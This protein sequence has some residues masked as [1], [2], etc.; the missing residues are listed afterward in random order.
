MPD[1]LNLSVLKDILLTI[2]ALYGA[3][4]STVN[5]RQAVRKEHR[6][7]AVK[8]STAMPAWGSKMGNCY[9]RIEATN[10]GHRPV[11]VSTLT[12]EL[13]SGKRI[14][15]IGDGFPGVSDTSLPASLSDGG[16]AH[17]LMAYKDI[18][19]ALL[20]SG[21]TGKTKITPICVD[22]L[23]TEHRGDPWEVD[24]HEIVRM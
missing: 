6:V 8:M 16:S 20:N 12:I 10:S 14:Y 24:P 17:L 19:H 13:P 1:W 11:T 18:G 7:L 4:L 21:Y 9:A 5:F 15:S 3:I 2:V 23:G 22:S